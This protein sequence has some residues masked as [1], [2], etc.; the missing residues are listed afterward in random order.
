M[1]SR[2]LSL[3]VYTLRNIW[4]TRQSFKVYQRSGLLYQVHLLQLTKQPAE[5]GIKHRFNQSFKTTYVCLFDG[6]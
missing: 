3:K 2:V 1:I 4:A 5:S 6:I